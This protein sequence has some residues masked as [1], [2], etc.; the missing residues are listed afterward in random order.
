[1]AHI[2]RYFTDIGSFRDALRKT[3]W[4]CRRKKVHVRYLISCWVSC[5]VS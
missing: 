2:L 1:M 5:Y 4:R 3:G